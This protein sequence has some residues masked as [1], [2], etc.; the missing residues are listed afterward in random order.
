MPNRSA[1]ATS[2]VEV[3][4]TSYVPASQAFGIFREGVRSSFLPWSQEFRSEREFT[5]RVETVRVESG[6]IGRI[7]SSPID[8]TRTDSHIA[9]SKVECVYASLRL[10]GDSS[11]RQGDNLVIA[12]P[13]DLVIFDSARPTTH[14]SLGDSDTDAIALLIPK[15]TLAPAARSLP[16]PY[17]IRKEK[18]IAPL[19][20]CLQFITHNMCV[21]SR[22]ELNAL[23]DASVKLLPLA[24]G[25]YRKSRN[26][27]ELGTTNRLLQDILVFIEENLRISD[28]SAESVAVNFNVSERY[29]HKLF[30][31]RGIAFSHYVTNSR[32][33]HVANDLLEFRRQPVSVLAYRWGFNDLSTFNRAFKSFFG[34]SPG[35]YRS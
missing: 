11:F 9:D 22:D 17:L 19:S 28:L 1:Q 15:T 13:G 7:Y 24:A 33:E 25:Y 31:T 4:D 6:V 35:Q 20:S 16:S 27:L 26:V 10:L 29:V 5:A 21:L 23:F 18:L 8:A 30:A 12:K 3:W 14:K 34:C 32:L 2:E